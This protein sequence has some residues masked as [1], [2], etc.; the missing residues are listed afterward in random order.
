MGIRA[1]TDPKEFAAKMQKALDSM[2]HKNAVGILW[3]LGTNCVSIAREEGTYKDQTGNLRGSIGFVVAYN[4]EILQSGG[5]KPTVGE[6]TKTIGEEGPPTGRQFAE[7]RAK[8]APRNKY[9]LVVVAGMNYAFWVEARHNLNVL[10]SSY[11]YA[12]EIVSNMKSYRE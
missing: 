1:R 12:K 2:I 5:F 3:M 10:E 4:G 11:L 6:K 8:E 9:V 7:E